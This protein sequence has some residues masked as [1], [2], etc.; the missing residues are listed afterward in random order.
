MKKVFEYVLRYPKLA[1]FLG[2]MIVMAFTVPYFLPSLQKPALEIIALCM[3][4][5]IAY[6][7]HRVAG[8]IAVAFSIIVCI[9]MASTWYRSLQ[10]NVEY[11]KHFE[12]L[13]KQNAES[14]K[15]YVSGAGLRSAYLGQVMSLDQKAAYAVDQ[16][17]HQLVL[18]QSDTSTLIEE[19]VKSKML[20]L[21]GDIRMTTSVLETMLDSAGIQLPGK[22]GTQA[23]A[24]EV[25]TIQVDVSNPNG[26]TYRIP[27]GKTAEITIDS[28]YYCCSFAELARFESPWVNANGYGIAPAKSRTGAEYANRFLNA[29]EPMGAVLVFDKQNPDGCRLAMGQTI[30]VKGGSITIAVNDWEGGALNGGFASFSLAKPILK[31]GFGDNQG[32]LSV[33][34]TLK[35]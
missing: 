24:E 4:T 31:G 15:T 8:G 30:V 12:E 17:G 33:L 23:D 22:K 6:T 18:L 19:S 26:V 5:A 32:H 21:A 7:F 9:Y 16:K 11:A 20:E 1:F 34:V 28:A 25:D 14:A 13:E 3:L 29:S 2:A 35:A 27:S 10:P